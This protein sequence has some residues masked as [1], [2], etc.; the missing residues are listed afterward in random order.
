MSENQTTLQINSK[1][2]VAFKLYESLITHENYPKY[3]KEAAEFKLK[4]FIAAK[5][6]VELGE[7]SELPIMTSQ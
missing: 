7:I 4:V 2:E 1:E 3:T 5:K 6:A